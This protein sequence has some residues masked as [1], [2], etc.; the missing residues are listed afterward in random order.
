VAASRPEFEIQV[1]DGRGLLLLRP[2]S[3]FGWLRVEQLELQ[4]P[5]VSFPL[6]ITRGMAQFRQHRCPVERATLAIAPAGLPIAV[7]ERMG[8]LAGAGF[9]R[10][11]LELDVRGA[12]LGA[13]ARVGDRTAEVCARLEAF[14]DGRALVVRVAHAHVLGF[15][16]RPALALAH[17][18]LCVL[19]GAAPS[20][21]SGEVDTDAPVARG[22]GEVSVRPLELSM[23]RVL[24]PAGWRVP[25]TEGLELAFEHDSGGAWLR[26]TPGTPQAASFERPVQRAAR[27]GDEAL[28]KNDLSGALAAYRAELDRRPRDSDE[29]R[30]LTARV[31]AV[32]CA[33]DGALSE[34]RDLAEQALE[35]WRDFGDG[36]L[37]LAQIAEARGLDAEAADR[38]ARAAALFAPV[39]AELA[40]R[41]WHAAARRATADPERAAG[42]HERVLD[43]R[44]DDP[45]SS[46]AVA[47]LYSQTGRFRDLA[48]LMRA[49]TTAERDPLRRAQAHLSLAQ[50]YAGK[51]DDAAAARAEL[52]E[53]VRLD[54]TSW[55][56]WELLARVRAQADDRGGA[57][58]ALERAAALLAGAGEKFAEARAHVQ[59]AAWH[60]Q[61]GAADRARA[62]YER[63]LALQPEE[64]T[65][66][67]QVALGAAR[68]GDVAQAMAIYQRL[69]A[70]CWADPWRRQR[71]ERELLKLLVD[72]GEL[73]RARALLE[74][75]AAADPESLVGL[76]A[77]ERAAGRPEAALAA[78]ERAFAAKDAAT[79][80]RAASLE[81]ERA[82]LYGEV[83]RPDDQRAALER[84]YELAPDSPVAESAA[85]ESAEL[86]RARSDAAAETRWLDALLAL[87]T[88]PRDWPE[89][90]LRRARAWLDA[91]DAAAACQLLDELHAAKAESPAA[92][93]LR[94]EVLGALEDHAGRA[95]VLEELAGEPASSVEQAAWWVLAVYSRLRAGELP[96]ALEAAR[97]ATALA[98]DDPRV[99]AARG[100]IAWQERDWDEIAT[101]YHEL[102]PEAKGPDRIEWARRLGAALERHGRLDEA[103]A[104]YRIA[105]EPSAP[106]DGGGAPLAESHSAL[107]EL[108][109]R[110][111]DYRGA[112]EAFRAAALDPRTGADAVTRAE[113]R[114]R[115][116]ELLW[117][118]AGAR[119]QAI[120]WLEESLRTLPSH[121]ASLDALESIHAELGDDAEVAR[122]AQRKL[123][124]TRDAHRRALAEDA[125]SR[126][127]LRFLAADAMR[128]GDR[129]A[130]ENFYLRLA[131]L[132]T[133]PGTADDMQAERLGALAI[134]AQLARE[135][136]RAGDAEN[137]LWAA[138]AMAT[139]DKQHEL[140]GRI[141]ELYVLT[142]RWADLTV[143]LT[144]HATTVGDERLRREVEL[145]GI[146]ILIERVRDPKA[147]LEAVS[148]ARARAGGDVELADAW[149]RA[150]R[151]ASDARELTAAL[152]ERAALERQPLQRAGVLLE[153]A[154]VARAALSDARAA[155]AF[156]DEVVALALPA[157]EATALAERSGSAR[158]LFH[159]LAARVAELE[160]Q[161]SPLDGAGTR[162]LEALVTAADA[163]G[164]PT[165]TADGL[166]LAAAVAP[167]RRTGA[168]WLK[169]AAEVRLAQ[170]DDRAR[171]A[172]TLERALELT[173]DDG[174]LADELEAVLL[175]LG[176]R[177]RA[178]AALERHLAALDGERRAPWLARLAHLH[179]E[180]GDAARAETYLAEA[181]QLTPPPEVERARAVK[182]TALARAVSKPR[183]LDIAAALDDARA[184]LAE[185]PADDLEG[186][187]EARLELGILYQRSG[188]AARARE[189]L[190]LVLAEKPRHRR[191]LEALAD[192][193]LA[194]ERF[195]DAADA[196]ERRARAADD[197][198]ERAAFVFRAGELYLVRLGDEERA[199]EAYLRAIDLDPRHAP[200][201]RR[202]ID[203]YWTRGE[204][205]SV[206]ELG[207]ALA[208]EAG[209]ELRAVGPATAARIAVAAALEEDATFT[210]RWARA[211]GDAGAD[212]LA[213]ALADSSR[214]GA[215]PDALVA[216][217]RLLC[218][219]GGPARA[220]LQRALAS[221]GDPLAATLSTRIG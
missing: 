183:E 206:L 139:P 51:L 88:R 163:S 7:E 134:L 31:L 161:D 33:R 52:E 212:A 178:A 56:A 184:R 85:R 42:Y 17:D 22:L 130:A 24:P 204:W 55:R 103:E 121:T 21:S 113:L 180:L 38:F 96:E 69:R 104:A 23:Q 173:P 93:R 35:R 193:A 108:R 122:I 215:P 140:L 94:A 217:A 208:A 205:S 12:K 190:E 82:R 165:L 209:E 77:L 49:R 196:I 3:F 81:F 145:R 91:G 132:E 107:G 182:R 129:A 164:A 46:E 143:L 62:A 136:N 6:D 219:P 195:A 185:L 146:R 117:R 76:A 210:S 2:R 50:L 66:L 5:Q 63:A 11:R 36:E 70:A 112:A 220:T 8:R 156:E 48:R 83:G 153:A 203:Y 141:E 133:P 41:A 116:A 15:L 199:S 187:G 123:D 169:Q 191:A 16:R 158:L 186:I 45:E 27:A 99:R 152:A 9:E 160:A 98:P 92:R 87:P 124:S 13:N 174:D 177:A 127:A 125:Q 89:L 144:H 114:R 170:T 60:E 155:D 84:A 90:A 201:L 75:S 198:V 18:L 111:G 67:E 138:V 119:A 97:R 14:V 58:L 154:Q 131:S 61:A 32:L 37:A 188:D 214:R 194:E 20:M 47:A 30:G 40:V 115:A 200:T 73:E 59:L 216:A 106:E 218:A 135:D 148:V 109:E 68:Q 126:P 151:L 79:G 25:T 34:A 149:V 44:P 176:D 28:A 102:V 26:Y 118:R 181:Q 65:V 150:A 105:V 10:T 64:P 4:I 53:C 166:E 54:D 95:R 171:A 86:A 157:S 142:E 29:A 137:H 189:Q 100:E 78:L 80:A 159:A 213:A 202:L 197:P 57:I 175:E 39:D 128:A 110:L 72:A 172:A 1:G 179:G 43:L 101:R 71:A 162:L 192:A 167:D 168:A 147:A 211:L 120:A 207:G 19:V 74:A 221:V